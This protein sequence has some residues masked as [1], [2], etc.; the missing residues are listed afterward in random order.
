MQAF[1]TTLKKQASSS[2]FVR[3]GQK[4]MAACGQLGN[5]ASEDLSRRKREEDERLQT[6]GCAGGEDETVKKPRPRRPHRQHALDVAAPTAG[7][8]LLSLH[9]G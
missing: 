3:K 9:E 5:V 8:S 2:R 4:K 1:K 6:E 7:P